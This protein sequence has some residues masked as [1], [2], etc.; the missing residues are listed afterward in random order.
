[1]FAFKITVSMLMNSSP[2]CL[3]SLQKAYVERLFMFIIQSVGLSIS[4]SLY[5]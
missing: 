2:D 5:I 4:L 3:R 1:M